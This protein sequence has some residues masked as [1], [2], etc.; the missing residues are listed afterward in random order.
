[1]ASDLLAQVPHTPQPPGRRCAAAA[2]FPLTVLAL[3]P[4]ALPARSKHLIHSSTAIRGPPR[5]GGRQ[6]RY[7]N[8]VAA[9]RLPGPV[10]ANY[11]EIALESLK[12]ESA[13]S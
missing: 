3:F 4:E 10:A 6:F 5:T 13:C 8:D 9:A 7:S 1:M 11:P 2:Q 12:G